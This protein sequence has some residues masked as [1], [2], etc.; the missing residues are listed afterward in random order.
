[1]SD[2]TIK[3]GHPIVCASLRGSGKSNFCLW[4]IEILRPHTDVLIIMA[5][6]TSALQY[7][8][9]RD[10]NTKIYDHLNSEAIDTCFSINTRRLKAGKVACHFL[11]VMDDSLTKN[12]KYDEQLNRIF[13]FGRLSQINCILLQQAVQLVSTVIRDNASYFGSFR[14]NTYRQ[15]QYIFENLL[16][17]CETKKEAFEV[18]NKLERFQMIWVDYTEGAPKITLLTPPLMTSPYDELGSKKGK[19]QSSPPHKDQTVF[20]KNSSIYELE[21]KKS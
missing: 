17:C 6:P 21:E 12:K 10:K 14:A 5:N 20:Y 2:L 7:E 13:Q 9:L 15:K 3:W 11:L 19:T 1:M 4:A 18:I 8:H 16:T